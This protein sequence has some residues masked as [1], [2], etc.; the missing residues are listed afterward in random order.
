MTEILFSKGRIKVLLATESFAIGVNMPARCVV[1]NGVRKNDGRGFRELLPGEYTQMSGRAGR[2]GIDA[3]GVVIVAGDELY[4]A[5]RL[6]KVL[7]GKPPKLASHFGVTYSMLLNLARSDTRR[8]ASMM[9]ASFLAHRARAAS[10]DLTAAAATLHGQL[11]ELPPPDKAA[12]GCGAD[13]LCEYYDALAE[14]AALCG[15]QLRLAAQMDSG[16]GTPAKSGGALRRLLPPGRALLLC[17]GLSAD[18]GTLPRLGVL[19]GTPTPAAPADDANSLGS[20]GEASPAAPPPLVLRC[21]VAS[22]QSGALP[23]PLNEVHFAP[24]ASMIESTADGGSKAAGDV[25][26]VARACT[27]DLKWS[28]LNVD[29]RFVMALCAERVSVGRDVMAVPVV[30]AALNGVA[31]QISLLQRKHRFTPL[32]TLSPAIELQLAPPPAS[33]ADTAT[34]EVATEAAAGLSLEQRLA[35]CS[36]RSYELREVLNTLP[37]AELA[38]IASLCESEARRRWLRSHIDDLESAASAGSNVITLLPDASRRLQLMRRLGYLDA[39]TAESSAAGASRNA[40]EL[41]MKGRV[42]CELTTARDELLLSEAVCTGV[43]HGLSAPEVAGLLS[44]FVSKG[45]PPPKPYPLSEALQ[46][47]RDALHELALKT[48]RVQVEN[49]TLELGDSGEAGHVKDALNECMIA[50]AHAWADGVPFA[51]LKNY[52]TLQ[53]GDIIRVLTRTEEL[54][55]EVR[56]AARL[57]GDALLAKTLDQALASIKRGVVAAPSLYVD[58]VMA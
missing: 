50:A 32:E 8:C 45:K 35:V 41:T 34:G 57:L 51:A 3:H 26:E 48:T 23:H 29:A 30:E 47:A 54:A 19:L 13:E 44:L 2:R 15:L 27:G 12:D 55:K 4:D 24:P 52:T 14:H 40:I 11:G 42:A 22:Q 16:D 25:Q 37:C 46:A 43:L 49:G 6:E 17:G 39:D 58:G 20:P 1:F 5:T 33:Q 10:R 9:R 18:L 38:N 21:L 7:V 53:E 36:V 56:K 28:V 31:L